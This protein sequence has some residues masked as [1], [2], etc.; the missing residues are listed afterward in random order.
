MKPV[1]FA[2]N[3]LNNGPICNLLAPLELSQSPLFKSL[4]S[5]PPLHTLYPSVELL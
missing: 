5:C 4:P 1:T 3:F 2:H